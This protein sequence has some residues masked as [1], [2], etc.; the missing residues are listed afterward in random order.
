MAK[1]LFVITEDWALL[2]HRMH[3]VKAAINRGDEVALATRFSTHRN[4]IAQFGVK[5]YDWTLTRK[6][7]NPFAELFALFSLFKII[8]DFRPDLVHAVAQKP[9]LYTGI[10][11]RLGGRFGFVAGLGGI[12]FIFNS[13]K[14]KA[15]LL[16][17]VVAYLLRFVLAGSKTS[18]IL[19]NQDNINLFEKLRIVRPGQTQLVKGSGV[20]IS[21]FMPMPYPTGTPKII[22]PAR[23]LWDKG[24]GEFV[25][26]AR[27]IKAQNIKADFILVGDIDPHNS[28]SVSYQNIQ[29]WVSEGLVEHWERQDNMPQIYQQAAVVCL[30]S[31]HEGLPKVLME[32]ASCA[33]PVI[34]FDV[35][36]CRE[37]VKEGIN[38]F[39]VSFGDQLGLEKAIMKLI[40]NTDLCIQMGKKGREMVEAEFSDEK[41]NAATFEI[42][43]ETLKC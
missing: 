41:I 16:R 3:L 18:F 43:K 30:P 35:P 19:Q 20:E 34:A 11:K 12:G 4:F 29:Q 6:S 5:T 33:R 32:A 25:A 39:L 24:V 27:A 13:A 37:I 14:L 36:G 22:L 1:V 42:W 17:P 31:Y 2:S 9:V 10:L 21:E 28:A 23:L 15:K 8:Q 7:L 40:N 26:A 38:G